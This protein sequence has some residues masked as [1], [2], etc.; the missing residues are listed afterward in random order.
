MHD[1]PIFIAGL[2]RTGKTAL[3]MALGAHPRL[4]MTRKT[5]MWSTFYERFGD[6]RDPA[7]LDAC[8]A[9]MF[10]DP[11][12]ARLLP[13]ELAVRRDFAQ[14]VGT[15]ADLFGVVHSQYA[16][17][18]GKDRW[19]EQMAGLEAF[20]EPI[21]ERWMGARIIHLVRH[22]LEWIDRRSQ[23]RP[24]GVGAELAQWTE[25]VHRAL[26]NRSEYPDGYMVVKFEALV[27]H[28]HRTLHEIG[29]FVGE[30]L[31]HA[32]GDVLADAL[33]DR[34]APTLSRPARRFVEEGSRGLV[35]ALAYHGSEFA[36]VGDP[37][38]I[39]HALASLWFGLGRRPHIAQLAST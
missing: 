4:S 8:I 7:S 22:P 31:N 5:R 16:R 21:F 30:E 36:E 35:S 37:G 32:M 34:G 10:S 6:L 23:L 13:E 19:G 2:P 17:R 20:A 39:E 14:G 38:R 18:I 29:S 1:D 12:V 25:S 15:Y 28:P 9:A 11:G 3:R 24:G 26:R 33:P 27:A